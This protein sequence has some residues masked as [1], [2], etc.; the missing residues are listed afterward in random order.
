MLLGLV[1]DTHDNV[2]TLDAALAAFRARGVTHV[3][4]AGDITKPATLA[5]LRGWQAIA[6]YGNNDLQRDALTLA[7]LDASIE[8]ADGWEGELGGVRV[9][10]L[11][12]DDGR[13]LKRAI[14]G[15]RFRLI[16]TGHS[17]KIRDE[18][19]GDTRL[20]NPGALYRA[21][22]HTCAVYNPQADALE[23]INLKSASS[24]D[25]VLQTVLRKHM[26]VNGSAKP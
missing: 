10:I 15:G 19:A 17:H 6:V 25:A 16:V 8:L 3:L 23:I 21:A 18:R 1:S 24:A 9:A 14:T 22:R 2:T 12:G 26:E 11:H 4:H 5:R 13:R 20:V 7:A